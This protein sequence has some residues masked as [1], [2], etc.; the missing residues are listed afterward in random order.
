MKKIFFCMLLVLLMG[1]M[2]FAQQDSPQAVK[3]QA[4]NK[5]KVAIDLQQRAN[6]LVTGST[7]REK[8]ITA[9]QLYLQ[10]G[11][12]F[13]QAGNIFKA[14][15]REFASE[16]DVESCNKATQACVEAITNV[17]RILKGQNIPAS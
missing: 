2:C 7:T 9:S 17:K 14:L 5:I 6:D 4:L 15:G 11:Q 3:D 10:A 16:E 12:L 1:S 13:E 8:L